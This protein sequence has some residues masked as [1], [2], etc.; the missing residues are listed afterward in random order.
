MLCFLPI[1]LHFSRFL[2]VESVV[3]YFLV[4]SFGSV[5]VLLG[6]VY[7][8]SFFFSSFGFVF[9][10]LLCRLLMKIGVFPFH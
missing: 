9:F 10:V 4:Q 7:Q 6:G 2:S 1:V 3:K 5:G 8:D